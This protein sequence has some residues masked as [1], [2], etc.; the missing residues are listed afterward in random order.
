MQSKT[1]L[2][3]VVATFAAAAPLTGYGFDHGGHDGHDRGHFDGRGHFFGGGGVRFYGGGYYSPYYY[4]GPYYYGSPYYG[5]G[6]YGGPGFGF[7]YY[8]HPSPVY[9]GYIADGRG[10]LSGEV[11]EVLGRRGYYNGPI[12]GEIGP[13]SRSAIRAFQANHGLATTGN[14]DRP[15]LRALGIN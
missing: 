13:R 4:G 1:L 9:R 14:I 2:F 3:S 11:Q 12:D 5:G 15:L 8:S 6:Y 10:S 7:S